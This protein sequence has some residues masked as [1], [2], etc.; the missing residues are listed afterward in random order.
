MPAAVRALP[1][2][3]ISDEPGTFPAVCSPVF[4]LLK[5]PLYFICPAYIIYCIQKNAKIQNARGEL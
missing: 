2:L 1:V 4:L 5:I 3:R